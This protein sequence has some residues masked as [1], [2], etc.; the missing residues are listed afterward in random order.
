[1]DK[2]QFL[3]II[4]NIGT[5]EDETE[6]RELLTQLKDNVSDIFDTNESLNSENTK[7]KEDNEKL[8]SANMKL[9][10]RVGAD[11]SEDDIK[12]DQVGENDKENNPRKFEDLFNEKGGLK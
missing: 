8:R 10:L 4:N 1:M 7:F 6:R 11:K 9:F 2:D 3:E 12:K 5:I